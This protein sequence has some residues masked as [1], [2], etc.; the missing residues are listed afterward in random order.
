VFRR[1]SP[2]HLTVPLRV[3]P[4]R[5]QLTQPRWAA[6]LGW[7]ALGFAWAALALSA[8][9]Q[10][11]P[12]WALGLG[13]ALSA[14]AYYL[15][16]QR[17]HA[18]LQDHCLCFRQSQGHFATVPSSFLGTFSKNTGQITLTPVTLQQHWT[19]IFGLTLRLNLHNHPHNK[20]EAVTVTLWRSQL[21]AQ[22]FRCLNIW[23][24]WYEAH[25]TPLFK[26]ETA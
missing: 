18:W 8:A 14:P 26:G 25:C 13:A 6:A 4:L 21:P 22:T 1:A 12:G 16:E 10:G 5:L 23:A 17:R 9:W 3:L 24:A 7:L 15:F 20:P 2:E 11:L 19:H